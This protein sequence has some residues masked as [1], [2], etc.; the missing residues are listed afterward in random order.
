MKQVLECGEVELSNH[1]SEQV[2]QNVKDEPEK[3]G[4]H[5]K[6]GD[7]V[8][9]HVHLL[10]NRELQN[11]KE[12]RGELSVALHDKLAEDRRKRNDDLSAVLSKLLKAIN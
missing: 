2:M 8:S 7:G 12:D 5:R 9:Q 10:G 3:Y 6:L 1:L 4:D 11:G